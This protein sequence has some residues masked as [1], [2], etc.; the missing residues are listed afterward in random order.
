LLLLH[1]RNIIR[2]SSSLSCSCI[3]SCTT[4]LIKNMNIF[5]LL[6]ERIFLITFSNTFIALKTRSKCTSS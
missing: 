2:I 5:F 4:H 6:D 3:C 1:W